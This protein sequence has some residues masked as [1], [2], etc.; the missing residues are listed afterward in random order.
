MSKDGRKMGR[1]NGKLFLSEPLIL[2]MPYIIK[3][4]LKNRREED[5][6]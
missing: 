1:E 3:K 4:V 6:E 5:G 2:C